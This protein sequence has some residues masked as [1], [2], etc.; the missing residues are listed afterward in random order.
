M[1]NE[2]TTDKDVTTVTIPIMEYRTLVEE[3]NNL[4]ILVRALLKGAKL[5][6]DKIS[7]TYDDR[8]VN[9]VLAAIFP[10]WYLKAVDGLQDVEAAKEA[11]DEED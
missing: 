7:L 10:Q 5:A 8:D 9:A 6:W 2:V 3:S 1:G 11:A 4:T